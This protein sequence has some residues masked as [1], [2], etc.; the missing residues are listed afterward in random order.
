MKDQPQRGRGCDAEEAEDAICAGEQP[1]RDFTDSPDETSDRM[2]RRPR[3][4]DRGDFPCR[5]QLF[6]QRLKVWPQIAHLNGIA[7]IHQIMLGPQQQPCAGSVEPVDPAQIEC[8]PSARRHPQSAQL[9]I[10]IGGGRHQPFTGRRQDER[11][12]RLRGDEGCGDGRHDDPAIPASAA[13]AGGLSN[14]VKSSYLA[15][16]RIWLPTTVKGS[17]DGP[18]AA[19]PL[20]PRF[21]KA[22]HSVLRYLDLAYTSGR[23]ACDC[24]APRRVG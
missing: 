19:H 5:A 6:D 23:L 21:P 18:Q 10:E 15:T 2:M 20:D 13:V 14:Y 12:R 24:G 17:G 22:R 4:A 7:A 16:G 9:L 1:E 3:V 8:D 11:T